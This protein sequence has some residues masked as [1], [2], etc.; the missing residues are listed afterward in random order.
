MDK[1]TADTKQA[2][3]D[4]LREVE[5]LAL[6]Q[7]D[8]AS[9][10]V[11][12]LRD[13]I[14][15]EVEHE[16]G[17]VVTRDHLNK[18]LA[19]VGTPEMVIGV[20]AG[21]ENARLNQPKTASPPDPPQPRSTEP[22]AQ[23]FML[24]GKGCMFWAIGLIL[25]GPACLVAISILGVFAALVTPSMSRVQMKE[26]QKEHEAKIRVVLV[27]IL[28]LQEQYRGQGGND[29]DGDGIADYGTLTELHKL[30]PHIIIDTMVHE[31]L[32]DGYLYEI[33]T[34]HSGEDGEP[35]FVCKVTPKSGGG[36]YLTAVTTEEADI[37]FY[38]D[39][40]MEGSVIPARAVPVPPVE[41]ED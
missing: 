14:V 24:A 9:E 37:R 31:G 15:H 30:A 26:V 41:A 13:H 22:G 16:A 27:S 38:R 18:V 35:H 25:I 11:S 7:G 20:E 3:E 39:E 2:L 21:T 1:W 12:G 29:K 23:K 8:D 36:M 10:I 5:Q 33:S 40:D 28:D 4:Y 32:F 6:Q 19:A 34:T 17:D